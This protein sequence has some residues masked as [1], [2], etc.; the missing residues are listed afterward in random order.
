MQY[1]Y[2]H[3]Y[4]N[5]MCLHIKLLQQ[6]IKVHGTRVLCDKSLIKS[7]PMARLITTVHQSTVSAVVDTYMCT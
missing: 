4:M 7:M 2:V 3:V 5:V 1:Q 6:C